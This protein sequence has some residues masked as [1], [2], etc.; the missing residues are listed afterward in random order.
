MIREK[1]LGPDHPDTA[2]VVNNLAMLLKTKGDCA[3]AEP[4]FRRALATFERVF[5]AN[6]P[7]TQSVRSSLHDVQARLRQR[8]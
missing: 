2:T 1:T 4:L 7:R 8:Q 6:A 5:G 3:G